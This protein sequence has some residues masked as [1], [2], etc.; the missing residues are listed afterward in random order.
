MTSIDDPL[1][2][3]ILDSINECTER[4][5]NKYDP[6]GRSGFKAEYTLCCNEEQENI[7]KEAIQTIMENADDYPVS[8]PG[9]QTF[10]K[11][12]VYFAAISYYYNLNVFEYY[13]D[14]T[15]GYRCFETF[16]ERWP[17]HTR[18]YLRYIRNELVA[19]NAP[20]AKRVRRLFFGMAQEETFDASGGNP[21]RTD[22]NVDAPESVAVKNM[23]KIID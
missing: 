8:G 18:D 19:G 15:Y 5:A 9:M 23:L 20:W 14:E 4:W 22:A 16:I 21:K 6:T 10:K 12:A 13:V 17:K 7:I 1:F 2:K 3:R 11:C